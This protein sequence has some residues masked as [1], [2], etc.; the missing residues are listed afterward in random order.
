MSFGQALVKRVRST[1]EYDFQF[2]VNCNVVQ[3]TQEHA[4][5]T[6]SGV[7]QPRFTREVDRLNKVWFN[8]LT[9]NIIKK[10]IGFTSTDSNFFK[11]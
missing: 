2:R 10:K 3:L 8:L 4:A 9:K 5:L 6:D 7:D 11:L 1:P